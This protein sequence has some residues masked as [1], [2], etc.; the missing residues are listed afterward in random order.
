MAGLSRRSPNDRLHASVRGNF[1][2]PDALKRF[3]LNVR[4]EFKSKR[5]HRLGGA[6]RFVKAMPQTFPETL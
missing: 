6:L 2:L 5:A 4:H 3:E 1:Q